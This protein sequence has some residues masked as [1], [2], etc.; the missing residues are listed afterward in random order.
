MKKYKVNVEII[1]RIG[2]ELEIEAESKED[3]EDEAWSK[4]EGG[5]DF[6]NYSEP[7]YETEDMEINEIE[8]IK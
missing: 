6:M 8:E 7:A 4:I 3:I 2:F 5:G 1:T